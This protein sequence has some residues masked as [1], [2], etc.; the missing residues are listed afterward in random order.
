MSVSMLGSIAV[1]FFED[2][3]ICYDKGQVS[4]HPI[5]LLSF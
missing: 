3:F 1:S 2:Q 4:T 5:I